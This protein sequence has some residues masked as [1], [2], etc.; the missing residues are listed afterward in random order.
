MKAL[1]QKH[2]KALNKIAQGEVLDLK[3]GGGLGS[4]APSEGEGGREDKGEGGEA[5]KF[6]AFN[7]QMRTLR[8][9]W[10]NALGVDQIVSIGIQGPGIVRGAEGLRL[11]SDSG[12]C[13]AT[14]QLLLIHVLGKT[15]TI[16]ILSA[17]SSRSAS[18][19]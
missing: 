3:L 1:P 12:D 5:R 10:Q 7:L 9:G 4:S 2:K 17:T 14:R 11:S 15:A 19:Q 6:V 8:W 13:T 16:L 18:P